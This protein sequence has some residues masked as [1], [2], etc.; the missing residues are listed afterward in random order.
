MDTIDGGHDGYAAAAV[1]TKRRDVL[2]HGASA[3]GVQVLGVR[4]KA[5]EDA[6]PAVT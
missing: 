5:R 3:D 6:G 2:R 1:V 4:P